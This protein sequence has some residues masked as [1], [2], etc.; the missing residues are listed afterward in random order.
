MLPNPVCYPE[1]VTR[2]FEYFFGWL[3][4][5]ESLSFAMIV[6]LIGFGLLGS[7]CS[8]FVRENLDKTVNLE[9][10]SS[11]QTGNLE[12]TSDDYIVKDL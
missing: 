1:E 6:G 4:I 9:N 12:N 8:S 10:T 3:L 5:P 11:A 7:A 2:E